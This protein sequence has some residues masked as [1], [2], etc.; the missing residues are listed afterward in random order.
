MTRRW[1]KTSTLKDIAYTI[2]NI[3]IE[4]IVF[5]TLIPMVDRYNDL[6]G[7]DWRGMLCEDD[8]E[9]LRE[10]KILAQDKMR[11]LGPHSTPRMMGE[12]KGTYVEFTDQYGEAVGYDIEFAKYKKAND[13][14]DQ[15]AEA[16]ERDKRRI[17]FE[18]LR[19]MLNP[20]SYGRGY[21]NQTFDSNAGITAPPNYGVNTFTAS[22]THYNTTGAA[23]I[24]NLDF[25]LDGM[26]H[27]QE[28]GVVNGDFKI[29]MNSSDILQV[30]KIAAWV[31][32]GRANVANVTT[33]K[34]SDTGLWGS[35]D[36]MGARFIT[37][38]YVPAGYVLILGATNRQ[39]PIKFHQSNNPQYRGLMWLPGPNTGR[40]WY[41][42]H[43]R[44]EFRVRT[45]HRWQ[46]SVY[47]IS[48]NSA[49]TAPSDY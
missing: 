11:Q 44:R 5:S 40:P 6:E 33:N 2:D 21:W 8:D 35:F 24:T 10:F 9:T 28:H 32:T 49:Y 43:V 20:Q 22:H 29:F 17:R 46:G 13:W 27:I 30:M 26:Q 42:S 45:F 18:L 23:T 12:N 14:I 7:V 1:G 16:I 25:F 47:Q 15:M 48:T 31:G 39:K 34:F 38:D 4:Q 37:E 41:D 36:L 19:E 3:L